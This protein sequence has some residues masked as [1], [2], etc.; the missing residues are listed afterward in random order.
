MKKAIELIEQLIK[1]HEESGYC[2]DYDKATEIQAEMADG[3]SGFNAAY[4]VG[5]YET[6]VNLLNDLK[7]MEK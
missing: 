1:E 7:R 4:D 6:L 3:E 2:T 5:R